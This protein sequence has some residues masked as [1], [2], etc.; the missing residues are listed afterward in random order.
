V[1]IEETVDLG[2]DRVLAS[3]RYQGRGKVSR[4]DTEAHVWGINVVRGDK[5]VSVQ[6]YLNRAD[7][8]EAAGLRE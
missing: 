7:A 5:I 6:T 4:A 1:E 3:V 8:L 2:G